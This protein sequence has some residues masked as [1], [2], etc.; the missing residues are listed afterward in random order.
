VIDK[1]PA[2]GNK[3]DTGKW[4][5][6]LACENKTSKQGSNVLHNLNWL[7]YYIRTG[8]TGDWV[9]NGNS[10][11]SRKI[12][13]L[14]LRL[15]RIEISWVKIKLLITTLFYFSCVRSFRVT[16]IRVLCNSQNFDR[17]WQIRCVVFL[18]EPL[19]SVHLI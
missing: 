8:R 2:M 1:P 12:V 14:L 19:P 18:N 6:V 10:W 5:T 9:R 15:L 7:C 11:T 13:L 17:F 3:W 4:T 16:L